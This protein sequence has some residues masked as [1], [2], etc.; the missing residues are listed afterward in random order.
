MRA[1]QY[2]VQ[3]RLGDVINYSWGAPEQ[4]YSAAFISSTH[5]IFA[6]AAAAHITVV[7]SSGDTG[8][9]GNK[10]AFPAPYYT[11]PVAFWPASDPDV[12]GV[13]GTSL[14]STSTRPAAPARSPLAAAGR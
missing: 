11:H 8:A 12:T 13:G 6:A 14:N 1:V 7:A 3:H 9:T 10:L 5:S 4:D 2:A